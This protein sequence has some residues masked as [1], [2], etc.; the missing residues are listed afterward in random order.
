[1]AISG[2]N[3]MQ[4]GDKSL[5]DLAAASQ[6][7]PMASSPAAGAQEGPLYGAGADEP[8]WN[9]VL[10]VAGA[11][12]G[13]GLGAT[14]WF[15]IAYLLDIEFGYIAIAIGALSGWGAVRLG[16]RAN[17]L[18]GMIAAVAGVAG[19]FA[20]SYLSYYAVIHGEKVRQECR[21]GV[22]Q[23]LAAEP[24]TAGWTPAQKEAACERAYQI[25]MNSP[26]LAYFKV[27]TQ[28]PKGFGM[29]VLFA[30]LGLYYGHR[31]GS[32]AKRSG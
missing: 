26:D 10:S 27:L 9:P 18:V 31:V 19:I 23:V 28:D 15:A 2:D 8:A 22:E 11:A 13:A 20:G 7:R 6:T 21:R 29:T 32:G 4:D 12:A 1:M 3:P 5:L 14:V 24:E 30:V 25:A 17:A 16:K